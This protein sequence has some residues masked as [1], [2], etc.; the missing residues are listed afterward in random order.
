MERGHEELQLL[1]QRARTRFL[2]LPLPGS[3]VA[4]GT[5][6]ALAA[7]GATLRRGAS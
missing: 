2:R 3:L 6:S 1:K 5:R 4:A 7:K